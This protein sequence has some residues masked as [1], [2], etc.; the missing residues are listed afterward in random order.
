MGCIAL[1]SSKSIRQKVNRLSKP[2]AIFALLFAVCFIADVA[3]SW[4]LALKKRRGDKTF[5]FRDGYDF[6]VNDLIDS[7]GV[8]SMSEFI[9]HGNVSC[10]EHCQ[11][12]SYYSY[13][14]CR[15]LRLDYRS[16]ARGGLL[17]DY[18]L[19]DWHYNAP[20]R[21]HGFKHP[22][23]AL[24]NAKRDF[25]LSDTECDI[26][27]KHMW[28]LTLPLPKCKESFIVSFVDKCCTVIEVISSK[29]NKSISID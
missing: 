14:I 6:C 19:Y 13:L 25:E 20:C 3:A 12:V 17:H 4:Y 10:L 29:A 5:N 8:E 9:Q 2:K 16:A 23:I 7:P 27:E 18:F 15:L 26:I 11:H 24:A 21:W 28:P 1:A 22:Y